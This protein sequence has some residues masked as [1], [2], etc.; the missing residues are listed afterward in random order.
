MTEEKKISVI[1]A[2]L[3]AASED[4]LPLFIAE[5][6]QDERSGVK[7]LV[8]QARRKLERLIFSRQLMRL[9]EKRWGN[10]L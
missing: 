10:W 4:M 7:A 9:C 8:E 3:K 6:Q 5:Y 1:K 2:E